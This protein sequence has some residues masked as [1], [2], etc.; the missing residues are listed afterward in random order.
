M[1]SGFWATPILKSPQF[2]LILEEVELCIF[3]TSCLT[4]EKTV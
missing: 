3:L 1:I 2:F 4:G